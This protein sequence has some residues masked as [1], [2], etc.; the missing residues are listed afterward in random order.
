MPFGSLVHSD[1]CGAH[2]HSAP[3]SLMPKARGIPRILW[4]RGPS[5]VPLG[6]HGAEGRSFSFSALRSHSHHLVCLEKLCSP[7]CLSQISLV[8]TGTFHGS[9]YEADDSFSIAFCPRSAT[10]QDQT[11]PD[12]TRQDKTRQDETR[13]DETRR[14][15]TRQDKTRQDKTR[16]LQHYQGKGKLS[17]HQFHS[18]WCPLSP[19]PYLIIQR[20]PA[21]IRPS[22][23]VY[24]DKKNSISDNLLHGG[25][26]AEIGLA[27]RFFWMRVHVSR[28]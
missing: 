4:L 5:L 15:E 13:R 16:Q 2:S 6:F 27:A 12:Q 17:R 9:R 18:V 22:T 28:N 1:D 21:C 25:L 24:D 14:D 20:I 19:H 10:R 8:L 3:D 11:R 7:D 26:S 23:K